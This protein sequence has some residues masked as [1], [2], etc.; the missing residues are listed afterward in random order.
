MEALPSERV[1]LGMIAVPV[2]SL[3]A[4]PALARARPACHAGRH[5]P[6]AG[7]YCNLSEQSKATCH[8]FTAF[9]SVLLVTELC[10]YETL[11]H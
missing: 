9:P 4:P 10:P 5:V 2:P 8:R 11:I 7:G 3:Q 1:N 6:E